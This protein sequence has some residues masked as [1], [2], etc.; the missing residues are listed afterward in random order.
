MKNR[1]NTTGLQGLTPWLIDLL[2]IKVFCWEKK[3]I[4]TWHLLIVCFFFAG[5]QSNRINVE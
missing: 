2:V 4:V 5:T 1:F 3:F